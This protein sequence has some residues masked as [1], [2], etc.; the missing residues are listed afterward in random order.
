MLE[1]MQRTLSTLVREMIAIISW[2]A[3]LSEP[4]V[5]TTYVALAAA[6]L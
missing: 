4:I 2:R 6:D 5:G 3:I 1:Y